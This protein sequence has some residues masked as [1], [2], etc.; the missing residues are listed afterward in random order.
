M[1]LTTPTPA[2]HS[3]QARRNIRACVSCHRE[4]SCLNCHSADP[5]RSMGANPHWPG[6]GTS[7]ACRAMASRNTRACLKCHAPGA[8][9]LSCN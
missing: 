7:A 1:V 5:A 6:F 9:E 2:S 4:E 3:F 8:P